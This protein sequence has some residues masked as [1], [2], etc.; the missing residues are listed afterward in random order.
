ML[1]YIFRRILLAVPTL[2]GITLVSF[3]IISLAP[4]DPAQIQSRGVMDPKFSIA[5]YE[6][7]RVYY[8]LDKPLVE[9]YFHWLGRLVRF[10]FGESMSTDRRPVWSK[11]RE[12]LWPTMSLAI[13]SL[14]ISLLLAIPI[15][16]HAAVRQNRLFDTI[17]S[18]ILYALYSVPSYVM[19]VP[20]ILLVGVQWDLLPF[21]GMTSDN[22]EELSSMGK[23]A[24]LVKHYTLITF[25]FSFGA[26]AYYSRFVR[27][28]MLEVLRQDYIQTAR[29]KGLSESKV[30][31]RHGFRNS[32]IPVL[33]LLGLL[34]PEIVGGS[35]ILEVMFN[36][37][38]LGRLFFD[39]M[40]ARDYPTIMAL[41]FVTA[42]LVLAGTLLADLLYGFADP[43]V[44]Y[45]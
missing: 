36:W 1:I 38:G 16:V 21:Q 19:A 43:R 41:S 11:I 8:Q 20:L 31:W 13:L 25:C 12:R 24:D 3:F 40:M 14:G 27:Q 18:T 9:R 10:D 23:A 39:S 32:L 44:S 6:D 22:Y 5:V 35:V 28:N 7:L 2:I 4:G 34:L 15:G 45:E 33:T 42:C 17:S 37:P 29:A 26:W 30:I